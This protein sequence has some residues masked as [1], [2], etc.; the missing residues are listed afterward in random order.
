MK[1]IE[2]CNYSFNKS[3]LTN[4]LW[5]KAELLEKIEEHNQKKRMFVDDTNPMKDTFELNS[6]G[7]E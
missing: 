7:L 5:P 2:L 4:S 1:L 6:G 3:W